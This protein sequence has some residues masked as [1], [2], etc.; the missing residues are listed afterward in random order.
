MQN[1]TTTK[2]IKMT[3]N[4]IIRA[5]QAELN[6]LDLSK[7]PY[8]MKQLQSLQRSEPLSLWRHLFIAKMLCELHSFNYVG[9]KFNRTHSTAQASLREVYKALNGKNEKLYSVI[10]ICY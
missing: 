6:E 3:K 4:E 7:C 2:L 1:N 8:S 5:I 10:E 9:K